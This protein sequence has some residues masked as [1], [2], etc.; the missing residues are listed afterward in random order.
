M[1]AA[2][3]HR[4]IVPFPAWDLTERARAL[5][6]QVGTECTLIALDEGWARA[7]LHV[8]LEEC[9]ALLAVTDACERAAVRQVFA[10]LRQECLTQH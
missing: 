1:D 2:V 6:R 9:R 8:Q 3:R 7:A 4:D 10:W 5:Y